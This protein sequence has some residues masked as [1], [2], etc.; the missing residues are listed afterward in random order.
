[1]KPTYDIT[2]M[3]THTPPPLLYFLLPQRN[4]VCCTAFEN[5]PKMSDLN[6]SP[7]FVQS[8]V[9]CL[10]T[11]F[12]RKL[13]FCQKLAKL[14]VE[15]DFFVIF[16]Q[17]VENSSWWQSYPNLSILFCKVAH[18]WAL[19]SIFSS[20][21]ILIICK[22]WGQ[23]KILIFVMNP[24]DESSEWKHSRCKCNTWVDTIISVQKLYMNSG[25]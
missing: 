6:F 23:I 24:K 14:N 7:I 5:H 18:V 15:C 20:K 17:C 16:K 8:K 1:M 19:T 13:H 11:L 25:L 3:C 2:Y 4:P 21:E 10:V 9:N 22:V 12:D